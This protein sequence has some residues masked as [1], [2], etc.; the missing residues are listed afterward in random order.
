MRFL[1]TN[2]A[3][4]MVIEGVD[5]VATVTSSNEGRRPVVAWGDVVYGVGSRHSSANTRGGLE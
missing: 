3:E 2:G 5:E 4:A 1:G